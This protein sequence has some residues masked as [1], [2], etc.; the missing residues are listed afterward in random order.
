MA[1]LAIDFDNTM[2]KNSKDTLNGLRDS[3]NLLREYGHK[4][5]IHSCNNPAW[6]EKVLIDNDIRFDFIWNNKGKP[7]ADLYIDDKGYHFPY[8][9][10]WTTETPSILARLEGLDN[11]KWG[12][13]SQSSMS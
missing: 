10:D 6:I 12:L 1:V 5:I 9:G 8:D 2:V 4:I 13:P 11:R 3:I 7:L